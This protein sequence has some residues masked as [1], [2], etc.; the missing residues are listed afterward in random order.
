M[1]ENGKENQVWA[2]MA[3]SML[4]E[5]GQRMSDEVI[6]AQ[7]SGAV[8]GAAEVVKAAAEAAKKQVIESTLNKTGQTTPLEKEYGAI[9][10]VKD[11]PR[12]GKMTTYK[13]GTTVTLTS[14]GSTVTKRPDGTSIVEL[15]DGN[16][17]TRRPDG[18]GVLER[19]NGEKIE[20]PKENPDEQRK[21][22]WTND[23]T[24]LPD[25][26]KVK[27]LP[28]CTMTRR[29][30]GTEI[31]EFKDGM[32][33]TKGTDGSTTTVFPD[34]ARMIK[35]ADGSGS[36]HFPDGGVMIEKADGTRIYDEMKTRGL[37][38][39]VFKDGTAVTEKKDGTVITEKP[40]GTIVTRNPD[41]T[42]TVER[43]KK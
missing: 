17:V 34:G 19:P 29:P 24:T 36:T 5:A 27:K 35:N 20:L 42:E 16:K 11:L 28:N 3:G 21:I 30:D 22:D 2:N 32:K 41:G 23:V 25:G 37:K 14:D 43:K 15:K 1:F 9:V 10:E 8:G 12:G 6:K 13:D 31:T 4:Q 26:T 40:D 33:I 39:T 38:I 7:M 18:T